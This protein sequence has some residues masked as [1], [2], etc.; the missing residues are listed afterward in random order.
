ML[1]IDF[2]GVLE[3][4]SVQSVRF[5]EITRESA[6]IFT[7][8]VPQCDSRIVH[9]VLIDNDRIQRLRDAWCTPL[10]PMLHLCPQSQPYT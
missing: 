4:A 1:R 6:V 3:A 2:H 5:P 7:V 8:L 10:N 9:S